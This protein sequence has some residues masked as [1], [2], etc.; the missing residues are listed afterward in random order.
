MSWKWRKK[1]YQQVCFKEWKYEIKKER[2][3]RFI[4][5]ELELSDDFDDCD[6]E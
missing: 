6:F 1:N 2:V 3:T 5:A 4:V